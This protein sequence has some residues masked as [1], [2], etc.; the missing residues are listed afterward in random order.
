MGDDE[1]FEKVIKEHKSNKPPI[2]EFWA[3]YKIQALKIVLLSWAFGVSVYMI[4][5][6]LPSY[7]HTFL[8]VKL[9]DALS[10]HTIA[11][12]VLML[13]I[14][15]FGILTDKF[16]RKKVLFASLIGF[17]VFSYPLFALMFESTF[18]AIL[19]ATL[20]FAIF[21]AMF[22]GVMP[23]L[24]TETFPTRVRYTGLSVS[25]NFALALFGGTTPLVCTWLIKISGGN[26]W[27]PAYYL[28]ATCI[29]G[30]IVAMYMPETFKNELE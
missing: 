26:V 7:L 19:I 21:E 11:I 14:P 17:V 2:S 18:T 30:I 5:I 6:F 24:M 23:A 16:G 22:Q 27:M 12:V 4:F 29:I 9:D 10:S 1:H 15:L 3:D 20:V 8:H 28:I 13:M 25:Y